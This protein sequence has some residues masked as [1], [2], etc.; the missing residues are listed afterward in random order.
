VPTEER[1]TK[2]VERCDL[3]PESVSVA[4]C[5]SC[6][7]PL[8]LTCA[9]PV[10]GRALGAECL[11]AA[12]GPDAIPEVA[13]R[14]RRPSPAFG[15]LTGVAFALGLAATVLPWSRFG[16]GAEPFGAWGRTVRWSIL[17]GVAA[18]AGAALWLALRIWRPAPRTW[19]RVALGLLGGLLAAGALLAVVRPPPFTRTW[20][21]A[22]IAASAGIL[23][24]ASTVRPLRQRR[25]AH[26]P[27]S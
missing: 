18:A 15:A 10:R 22:W 8:C 23:A 24:A 20:I 27:H 2:N 6:G 3:H 16:M 14:V 1:S 4:R 7:R 9:T 13:I 21:G 25:G 5:D 26:T 17:A 12:L 19:M 11:T